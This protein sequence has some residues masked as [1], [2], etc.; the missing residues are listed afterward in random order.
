[1]G[2]RYRFV[3]DN[4]LVE[5]EKNSSSSKLGFSKCKVSVAFITKHLNT[6]QFKI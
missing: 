1:M 4:L 2:G 5:K 6:T 3:G